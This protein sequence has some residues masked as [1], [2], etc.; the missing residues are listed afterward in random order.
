M[1]R[2]LTLTTTS[3]NTKKRKSTGGLDTSGKSDA[4]PSN[5]RRKTLD[6]F[7]APQVSSLS[8]TKAEKG[9]TE[10]V[11]LNE[12]QIRVLQMVVEEGKSVFFTGAAG[13]YRIPLISHSLAHTGIVL[14]LHYTYAKPNL[15]Q[16]QIRAQSSPYTQS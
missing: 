5:K 3:T 1:A 14:H 9:P 10:R 13:T 15:W 7:F 16:F 4:E 6:A 11:A 12:E 2:S 8:S